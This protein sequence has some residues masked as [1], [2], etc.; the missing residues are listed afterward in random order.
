MK[1]RQVITAEVF[2]QWISSH[3]VMFQENL[4]ISDQRAHAQA[5]PNFAR[6]PSQ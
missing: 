3:F 2:Q 5:N 4:K 6:A 1:T